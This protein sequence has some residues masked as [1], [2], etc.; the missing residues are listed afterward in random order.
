MYFF[1]IARNSHRG[2]LFRYKIWLPVIHAFQQKYPAETAPNASSITRLGQ[3]FYDTGSVADRKQSGIAS[4]VKTKVADVETTL[5][6][7][8]KKSPSVYI[9]IVTKIPE[10]LKLA[11][12]IAKVVRFVTKSPTWTPKMTPT[13]L[14]RNDFT[15]FPLNHHYDVT[16]GVACEYYNFNVN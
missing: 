16:D 13:W 15:K 1:P 9:N 12:M 3:R 4:I 8:P 2:I 6:R 11:K 14:Y 7:S 10:G 5:Q